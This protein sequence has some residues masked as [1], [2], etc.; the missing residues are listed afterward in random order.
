MS[1]PTLGV[2][3]NSGLVHGL[4]VWTQP[5]GPGT[6][7]FPQ[8]PPGQQ[9]ALFVMPYCNHWTNN[10]HVGFGQNGS[11]GPIAYLACPL[12]SCVVRIFDPASLYLD[13]LANYILI[14]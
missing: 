6:P 4:P 2:M 10:I 5:G 1:I 12:C 3:L 11:G 8:Q 14:P 7:V 9:V 13:N